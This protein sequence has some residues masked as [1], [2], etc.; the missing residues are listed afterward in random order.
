VTHPEDD[1]VLAAA[2]SAIADYLVTGDR[3]LQRIAHFHDVE[4]VTPRAFHSI[5]DGVSVDPHPLPV[6]AVHT[7]S[8]P[9]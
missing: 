8:S 1:L 9:P 3:Q 4:I 2:I 6:S 5:L 7:A